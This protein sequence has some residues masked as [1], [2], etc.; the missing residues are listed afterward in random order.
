LKPIFT[1]ITFVPDK[2]QNRITDELIKNATIVLYKTDSLGHSAWQA[3][4]S[5]CKRFGIADA[6]VGNIANVDALSK[7]ICEAIENTLSIAI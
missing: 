7:N 3:A 5:R 4:T 6:F 1:E 2:E